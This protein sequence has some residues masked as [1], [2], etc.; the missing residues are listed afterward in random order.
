MKQMVSKKPAI[1][2]G[3]QY[4]LYAYMHV[5]MFTEI[6]DKLK[7]LGVEY[8]SEH[9]V[10]HTKA[11]SIINTKHLLTAWMEVWQ[12]LYLADCCQSTVNESW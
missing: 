9:L 2:T 7:E 11:A 12:E 1:T 5:Y 8:N 4:L 3:T 10:G 6:H